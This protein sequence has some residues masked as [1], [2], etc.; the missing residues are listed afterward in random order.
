[1]SVEREGEGNW[2]I[3]SQAEEEDSGT[4]TCIVSDWHPKSVEH[5]VIVRSQLEE[6]VV[7]QDV[8]ED[9]QGVSSLAHVSTGHPDLDGDPTL[10]GDYEASTEIL[11][12][13]VGGLHFEVVLC[14]SLSGGALLVVAILAALYLKFN[15]GRPRCCKQNERDQTVHIQIAGPQ[16]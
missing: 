3:V 6:K 9:G 1:M 12:E 4:Y 8:F 14:I 2:L 16:V 11:S 10:F 13:Q 7:E 5:Q 15:R